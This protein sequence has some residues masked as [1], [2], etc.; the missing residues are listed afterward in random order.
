MKY[1]LY[2]GVKMSFADQF[3]RLVGK[4]DDYEDYEIENDDVVRTQRNRR[5]N[6]GGKKQMGTILFRELFEFQH[7][8]EICEALS[9][10]S[11][12]VCN[13]QRCDDKAIRRII[14]FLSGAA[15]ILKGS[16]KRTGDRIYICAPSTVQLDGEYLDDL[17]TAKHQAGEFSSSGM[18]TKA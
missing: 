14:D 1:D 9:E 10:G 11:T 12:V 16:I 13:L 8:V 4:D 15:F 2:G 7:V 3:K 5:T 6:T 17:E 18:S